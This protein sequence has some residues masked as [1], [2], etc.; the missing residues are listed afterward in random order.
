LKV[1]AWEFFFA[2]G[3]DSV[4]FNFILDVDLLEQGINE[5]FEPKL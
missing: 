2:R 3:K 1:K 4:T 5:I